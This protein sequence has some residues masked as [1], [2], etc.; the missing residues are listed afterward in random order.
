MAAMKK[1]PQD[2]QFIPIEPQMKS[3]DNIFCGTT[4]VML[5]LLGIKKREDD[6]AFVFPHTGGLHLMTPH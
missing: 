6:F 2:M 3:Q 1:G 4:M 5:I